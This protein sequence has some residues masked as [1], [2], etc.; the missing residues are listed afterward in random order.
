MGN[1]T[2]STGR[3]RQ[4]TGFKNNN[5]PLL[6]AT[7]AFGM[8]ID[9]PN[10]RYTVHIT[11]PCS[12]EQYYQEAGRAGRDGKD[13]LSVLLYSNEKR[14][15]ADE[16]LNPIT[17]PEEVNLAVKSKERNDVLNA[18]YFHSG[19]FKGIEHELNDFKLISNV[20]RLKTKIETLKSLF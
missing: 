1:W 10:I 14:L 17:P 6:V 15:D 5:T 19:S 2:G 3:K 8:G 20:L 18:L 16:L 11:L 12:I 9:K 4:L 13:S 7:N